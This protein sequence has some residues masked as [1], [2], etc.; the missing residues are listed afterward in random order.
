MRRM[1]SRIFGRIRRTINLYLDL[2]LDEL[3]QAVADLP[4]LFDPDGGA[5]PEE[6]VA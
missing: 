5:S 4:S 2:G 1:L 3:T 6:G